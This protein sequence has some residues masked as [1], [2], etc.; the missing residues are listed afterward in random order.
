MKSN[1]MFEILNLR[2]KLKDQLNKIVNESI[3]DLNSYRSIY[4]K[5]QVCNFI[6][7]KQKIA[8]K[9]V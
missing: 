8:Q 1:R 4:S 9:A 2:Q 6:L 3:I 7:K 5:L